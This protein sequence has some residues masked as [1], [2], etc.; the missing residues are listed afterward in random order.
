MMDAAGPDEL[1][2]GYGVDASAEGTAA[3]WVASEAL[4]GR[5]YAEGDLTPDGYPISDEMIEGAE[6]YVT[7]L[8]PYRNSVERIEQRVDIPSIHPDCWGTPD[9]AWGEPV[10][11]ELVVA[12]YKFGHKFVEVFEN[13]QLMAYAR[14]LC[15][16]YLP[17]V[18]IRLIV[19]QPRSFSSEG[20]VREWSLNMRDLYEQADMI[21]CAIEDSLQPEAPTKTSESC[22]CCP[23][24]HMCRA[25]LA[26][27]Q[28]CLDMA[29]DNAP[30]RGE[31]ADALL[32][33]GGR[34]RAN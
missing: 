23:V 8:A 18:T 15:K 33:H 19:V 32:R 25:A 9:Y 5:T 6:A 21:R 12:D 29:A 4:Q 20:P 28:N 30:I 34:Q 17:S 3:H 10:N 24:R 26:T 2:Q 11:G 27:E 14:G 7:A 22:Y 31:T 1:L 13:H 16:S